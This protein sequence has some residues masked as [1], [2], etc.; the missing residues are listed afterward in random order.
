MEAREKV[1]KLK[2]EAAIQEKELAEKAQMQAEYD[3]TVDIDQ[4]AAETPAGKLR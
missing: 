1:K 3:A 4:L 2:G